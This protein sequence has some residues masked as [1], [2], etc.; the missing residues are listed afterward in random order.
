LLVFVLSR[1]QAK[2]LRRR[3]TVTEQASHYRPEPK[4]VHISQTRC[5]ACKKLKLNPN[6]KDYGC[7]R[8]PK[9]LFQ[10]QE[11]GLYCWDF[12]ALER[13]W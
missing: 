12:E 10:L 6:G 13:E 1:Y 9:L 3:K 2:S 7:P 11:F 4:K 8:N 5:W